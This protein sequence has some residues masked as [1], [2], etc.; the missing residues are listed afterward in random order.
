MIKRIYKNSDLYF[1]ILLKDS[2][3][4]V[5]DINTIDSIDLCFWTN[6]TNS[7]NYITFNKDNIID[8]RVFLDN[9]KLINLNEGLLLYNAHYIID[10]IDY[11]KNYETNYFIKNSV[12]TSSSADTYYSKV[13]IDILLSAKANKIDVYTKSEVDA[14]INDAIVGGEVDLSNYYNKPEVDELLSDKANVVDIPS[15]EHLATKDE[16]NSKADANNV[17]SKTEVDKKIDDAVIGGEVDLSNYYDKGEVDTMLSIKANITDIPSVENLATKDEVKLKADA[18]NVYTKSEVDKMIDE[19][20]TSG[21]TVDLSNYYNKGEVDLK[22][23][24]KAN[25][26]DVYSKSETYSKSEIDKKIDD[27][28]TSGET[29][30]LS[31][32]YTKSES[33]SKFATI[34]SV[35]NKQDKLVSGFSIKTINGQSLLGTGNIT[36]SGGGSVDLSNYYTKTETELKF[37]TRTDATY[38]FYKK[39]ETY[40]QIEVNNLL[41]DKAD[42]ATTY[43][44]SD[45]DNLLS[46]KAD[47][48]TTYNKTDVDVK[49]SSKAN[50]TDTYKKTEVDTKLSSKADANNVYSK[51]E[52]DSKVKNATYNDSAIVTRISNLEN[53]ILGVSNKITD[54]N[55]MI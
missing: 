36:I 17:Y 38:D 9:T 43:N 30:D 12:S 31:N 55:S 22:L 49:L 6:G 53:E 1:D 37:Y 18:N 29:V 2:N 23:S 47:T 52:V 19:I 28:E 33:N 39:S 4:E 21:G 27:I 54:I 40:K 8:N 5:I 13:E 41:S 35:D 24:S 48:A 51:S 42:A 50:L 14:K 7:D 11:D 3:N 45:V 16:L 34:A 15:I 26:N 32:Y 10:S 20:E 25:S 46:D 44:K